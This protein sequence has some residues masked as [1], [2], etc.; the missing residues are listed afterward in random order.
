MIDKNNKCNM[1]KNINNKKSKTSQNTN[2]EKNLMQIEKIKIPKGIKNSNNE[3]NKYKEKRED[4]FNKY[5]NA[6]AISKLKG[7]YT[8]ESLLGAN[9]DTIQNLNYDNYYN[10]LI[11]DLNAN[12]KN[13]NIYNYNN[14]MNSTNNMNNEDN[15]STY[16]DILS[17]L[18]ENNLVKIKKIPINNNEIDF[19]LNNKKQII[20]SENIDTNN[21]E[22]SNINISFITFI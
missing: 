22:Q 13:N 2:D 3:Q 6:K 18:K 21:E 8:F 20:L 17:A 4:L 1:S 7:D 11:D 14:G 9:L 10:S 12:D 15:N 16:L 5:T 19:H